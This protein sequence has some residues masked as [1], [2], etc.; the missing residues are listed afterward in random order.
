MWKLFFFSPSS[1]RLLSDVCK[2]SRMSAAHL[3]NLT[4]TALWSLLPLLFM[5]MLNSLC[6]WNVFIGL[7]PVIQEYPKAEPAAQAKW[8]D[9]SHIAQT[10]E[11]Q[12][13]K[14]MKH[15]LKGSSNLKPFLWWA[16]LFYFGLCNEL[17]SLEGWKPH[18]RKKEESQ[19]FQRQ[20][21]NSAVGHLWCFISEAWAQTDINTY[22]PT[23][24]F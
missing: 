6:S 23:E 9:S 5:C 17:W 14:I 18:F 1:C 12:V 8:R 11:L 21:V 4:K 13:K 15:Q 24:N 19:F 7:W 20:I 2:Q 16:V 22:T 10:W 3:E